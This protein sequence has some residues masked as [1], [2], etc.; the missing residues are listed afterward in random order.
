MVLN[1]LGQ[2]L[3]LQHAQ[4]FVLQR[5]QDIKEAVPALATTM[6]WIHHVYTGEVSESLIAVARARESGPAC[7]TKELWAGANSLLQRE[8]CCSSSSGGW[9]PATQCYLRALSAFFKIAPASVQTVILGA[10]S[11]NG[12]GIFWSD[13]GDFKSDVAGL[14]VLM[15]FWSMTTVSMHW[16]LS[17]DVQTD[18]SRIRAFNPSWFDKAYC[19]GAKLALALNVQA[20]VEWRMA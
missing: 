11:V 14:P 6:D 7:L 19:Q 5:L 18:V 17:T 1:M 4:V 2:E 8:L 13:L 12:H 9:W 16:W 15:G 3:G 10:T 20:S